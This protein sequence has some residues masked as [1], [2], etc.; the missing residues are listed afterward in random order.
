MRYRRSDGTNIIAGRA[1]CDTTI[2]SSQPGRGIFLAGFGFDRGAGRSVGATFTAG[3]SSV[4]AAAVAFVDL[5]YNTPIR[6]GNRAEGRPSAATAAQSIESWTMGEI[7]MGV[8][9][10]PGKSRGTQ[11]RAFQRSVGEGKWGLAPAILVRRL[12]PFLPSRCDLS[13]DP[14]HVSIS[15]AAEAG[16]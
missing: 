1:V 3:E 16:S 5:T 6:N 15:T 11:P 10:T 8:D 12:S 7:A 14:W 4:A 2:S 9:G 13:K